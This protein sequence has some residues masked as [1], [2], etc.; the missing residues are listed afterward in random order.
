MA[1]PIWNISRRLIPL[2][3]QESGNTLVCESGIRGREEIEEFE[4]IGAHA[5]LIGE[6]LMNLAEYSW[7][8][9]RIFGQW[10][11]PQVKIKICGMTQLKDALFA[12]E[13]GADAVGFVF[14]KKSPRSITMKTVRRNYFKT[15]ALCRYGGS[16]R[17]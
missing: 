6:S 12:A 15:A 14:Y 4:E 7:K 10:Q 9:E 5:F 1:K 8:I 13:Q 3:L 16:F 2:A 11:N 17:Q